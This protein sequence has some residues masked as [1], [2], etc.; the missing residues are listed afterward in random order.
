MIRRLARENPRWGYRRIHGELAGL[1]VKVAAST[2]WEIL[3]ASGINPAPRRTGPTWSQFLRSQAEAIL[4]CDFF[5]ADLLD[6]TQAHVLAVIEHA[7]R[8]IRILGVTLHP[9]GEWAAQQAR[10]LLMDLGEQAHRVKFMIRDRGSNFTAAFDAVL[11]DAG[12]R[13]VLCNVRTPRMNAITERWIGGCRREL[14][15]RTLVWN[16]AHLRRIL[17]QY[18]THHNQHRPHRSLRDAAPLKPLPEPVHLDDYRVR[19]QARCRWHDQR[20]S[21]GRMTRTRLPA[22]TVADPGRYRCHDR[23]RA[24][25]KEQ[26]APTW[27][28]TYG[29]HPLAAF[30][31][32][33]AGAAGE[34]LAIALRPGNAGSSTA[35]EHIEVTRLALAQLPRRQRRRVLIR[36]DSGGGTHDFLAWLAS[37]GRRLH[38]S[39]GMT[40]TAGDMHQAILEPSGAGAG[41]PPMTLMARPGP[42]PGGRDRQPARSSL[43]APGCFAGGDPPQGT[44][45]P[46]R[47]GFGGFTDIERAIAS[48]ASPPTPT[49]RPAR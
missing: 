26:A 1:G 15:D 42:R 7:T 28:K 41:S 14:L 6:G 39:V 10:N 20:I 46:R 25:E 3:K 27:K 34:A 48:P 19:R 45:T 16:Q 35:S 31:D 29:F 18:E 44:P 33:G 49:P 24:S 13:T 43:L 17:R 8:R 23:G 36:T 38:Y 4:A 2:V 47:T 9:T 32:H 22:R 40:I 5:T 12:I 11:T 21:P 30:A 37:P